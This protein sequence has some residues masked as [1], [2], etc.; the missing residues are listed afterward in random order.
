MK[1][2]RIVIVVNNN[3]NS[4]KK[5]RKYKIK[6]FL[7]VVGDGVLPK[8]VTLSPIDSHKPMYYMKFN[9]SND[10]DGDLRPLGH[11][12]YTMTITGS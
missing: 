6:K 9:V 8:R 11:L 3:K 7:L 5:E 12:E 2:N 10:H 4:S 1:Y